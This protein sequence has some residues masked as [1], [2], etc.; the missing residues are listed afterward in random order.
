MTGE[1]M[2]AFLERIGHRVVRSRSRCWY[3]QGWRFFA[4][5]PHARPISPDGAELRQVFRAARCFGVRFVSGP[6]DPGRPS[7][8]LIL[9]DRAYG[10]DS[11]SANSRSKVRRGLKDCEV[12]RLDPVYVRTHGRPAN[13]DTLRRIRFARDVYDWDRYWDAVAATADVEVWGALRGGQLLAYLVTVLVEGSAE[14][15]IARSADDGLR[16]YP[17]NALLYTVARDLLGRPEIEQLVFGLESVEPV[18]GVDSFKESM[19]FERRPIRQRIVFHPLA[20]PIVRARATARIA[21]VLARRR[22]AGAFW[23]K[24]EGVLAFDGGL[25]PRAKSEQMA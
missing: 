23:R 16:H 22:G 2:A 19:G 15:L 14:L 5:I 11:L 20:Q 13:E 17:N 6:H 10:L 24:L 25:D 12:R 4:A 18:V 3:E 1:G 9:D 7:Y 21:R 8:A